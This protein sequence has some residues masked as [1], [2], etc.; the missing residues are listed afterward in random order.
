[1][2]FSWFQNCLNWQEPKEEGEEGEDENNEDEEK[3]KKV[4]QEFLVCAFDCLGQSWPKNA[5]G[6]QGKALQPILKFW[7][8][9]CLVNSMNYT[10]KY[11]LFSQAELS[12]G[13]FLLVPANSQSFSKRPWLGGHH[14]CSSRKQILHFYLFPMHTHSHLSQGDTVSPLMARP[15]CVVVQA[16][17]DFEA[18]WRFLYAHESTWKPECRLGNS[19]LLKIPCSIFAC[20]LDR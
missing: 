3:D 13:G 15:S 8:W 19:L 17:S 6:S 12:Q 5:T 14:H 1:M 9:W 20:L 2:L 18:K 10:M 11:S 16:K 4:N 7:A